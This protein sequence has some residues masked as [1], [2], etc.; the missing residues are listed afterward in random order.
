[1]DL[2]AIW[3][4]TAEHWSIDQADRYLGLLFDE[5]EHLA[6]SPESG[7]DRSHVRKGYRCSQ[8]KS[9]V[10]YYRPSTTGTG[11]EVI[12]ILHQRM[13]VEHGLGS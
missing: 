8:V 11:I 3:L 7:L 2:E 1:M 13:D 10:I 6:G 5:I 9:H 12:R 4:Y